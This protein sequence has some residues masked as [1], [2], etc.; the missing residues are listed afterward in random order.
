MYQAEP[1]MQDEVRINS[2]RSE[3]KKER[4]QSNFKHQELG[5]QMQKYN[6][7]T[8]L[9]FQTLV[10]SKLNLTVAKAVSIQSC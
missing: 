4:K 6:P 8:L 2:K 3:R 9:L 5:E 1:I 10:Y 7:H